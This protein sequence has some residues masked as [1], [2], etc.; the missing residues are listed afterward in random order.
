VKIVVYPAD[1][2]GCGHHRLIWPAQVLQDQGH[3]VLIV[4]AED[5]HVRI[6]IDE[7]TGFVHNVELPEDIDVIV[8]QRTT[9]FRLVN[10]IKWLRERGYTVVIDVDDDLTNIHPSNPAFAALDPNAARRAV[11]MLIRMGRVDPKQKAAA[12]A[13]YQHKF[14]HSWRHLADAC[15]VA[16]LVTVSTPGLLKQYASHGR[17]MWFP[18]YVPEHY[19]DQGHVD[20][21]KI[22]WPAALHSHP[23]D[24]S[25]VGNAIARLVG[26]GASF[27]TIGEKNANV[28]QAFGLREEPDAWPDTNVHEWP[29]ALTKIG[30]G[31]APLADTIFNSRKSWL[32]PIEMSACGVPWV[33]S[34][35]VEYRRLHDLGAGVLADKPKDWYRALRLLLDDSAARVDLSLRG[36]AVA[37]GLRLVDNA[38][39]LMEAWT[40]AR[41]RDLERG[42]TAA[43]AARASS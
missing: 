36:V 9:D 32:K 16:S 2:Y 5:R 18:N 22:V 21:D 39:R 25:A 41:T 1:S 30:I 34:P 40:D 27:T 4:D 12:V 3:D 33:A 7:G 26:E 14:T 19:F 43:V 28:R 42:A 15:K 31:I 13:A 17:G 20:S 24:P 10:A 35:R 8:F 38:W 23:N 37:R 29:S 6:H 11:E